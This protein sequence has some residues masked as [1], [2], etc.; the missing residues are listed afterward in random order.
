M[1]LSSTT[2]L[3]EVQTLLNEGETYPQD[4][5]NPFYPQAYQLILN[6]L[7]SQHLTLSAADKDVFTFLK[8]AI[9]INSGQT[10]FASVSIRA[11]N[12]AAVQ[13]F[14]NKSIGLFGPENQASSNA[15]AAAFLNSVVNDPTGTGTIPNIDTIAQNDATAGLA[16]LGLGAHPDAWAGAVPDG[17]SAFTGLHTVN[18][19]H[20]LSPLQQYHA[21]L[22]HLNALDILTAYEATSSTLS[23]STQNALISKIASITA[24]L[25]NSPLSGLPELA[26]GLVSVAS[27]TLGAANSALSA[28]KTYFNDNSSSNFD[29][30]QMQLN[31][32]YNLN[33][34]GGGNASSS[35]EIAVGPGLVLALNSGTAALTNTNITHQYSWLSQTSYYDNT[36]ETKGC[37][38]QHRRHIT[39]ATTGQPAD[40]RIERITELRER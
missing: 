32:L 39:G 8:T 17:L 31:Q 2:V 23:A 15:V 20:S 36:G 10:S 5:P 9:Q 12:V 30:L 11:N 18:Y 27:V 3:Q 24:N 26:D 1:Q 21:D 6:D 34:I 35:N 29:L 25:D 38:G 14:Q 33:G 22:I 4:E 16:S 7:N 40:R 13:F 19:Y 28:L 37:H